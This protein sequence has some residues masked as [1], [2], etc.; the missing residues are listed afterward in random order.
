MLKLLKLGEVIFLK[1]PKMS[2]KKCTSFVPKHQTKRYF[3]ESK[4]VVAILEP[5]HLFLRETHPNFEEETPVTLLT[6]H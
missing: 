4:A 2:Q 5:F 3:E 6:L 1:I